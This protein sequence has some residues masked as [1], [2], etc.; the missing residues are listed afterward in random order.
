MHDFGVGILGTGKFLPERTLTNTDIEKMVD[1]SDEWITKRTGIKQRHLLDDDTPAYMMGAEAARF[2]IDNAGITP[3]DIDLIIVTTEAPDYLT[4]SMACLIQKSIGAENASAFDINAA[5]TGFVYAMTI[6]QQFIISG[7]YRYIL[8]VSCEG[9]SR[10]VDWKNRNTCILFGDGAGAVVLGRVNKNYGIRESYLA[11]HGD[12]GGVLNIPCC[13]ITD[14]DRGRRREGMERT[15]WQDG[16][17][18]FTFAVRIMVESTHKVLEKAGKTIRNVNHLI[19][20]QANL[21]IIQGAAKRL[22]LEEEKI[23]IILQNTGNISSASI[24]VALDIMNREGRLNT[25]D[26]IV[27]V[28]FGG[29][30]T[31]GSLFYVWGRE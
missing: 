29:G 8:I 15:I 22:D 9:L 14:E 5:C 20:H 25:G 7:Y 26:S 3:A 18:V 12:A 10:V 6:A 1:T 31:N 23:S 11:S 19:P 21:R 2:A 17:E 27:M 24:P 4:P 16:S 28:A 30:L 13:F